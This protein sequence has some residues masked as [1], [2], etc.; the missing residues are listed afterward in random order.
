MSKK[1][2]TTGT[3]SKPR[4]PKVKG[5][6]KEPKAAKAPKEPKVP[7]PTMAELPPLPKMP[8][9]SR[10]RKQKPLVACACGCGGETRSIWVPGHD[11]YVKGWALRVERELCKM[12]DVPEAQRTAVK[13]II[14]AHKDAGTTSPMKVVGGKDKK[15]ANLAPEPEVTEPVADDAVNQ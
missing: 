7:N 6:V 15:A 13:A 12:S 4:A 3:T 8:S 10:P 11:A 9:A 1:F 14:K 5:E 2:A